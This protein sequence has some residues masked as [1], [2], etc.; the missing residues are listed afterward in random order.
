VDQ[1]DHSRRVALYYDANTPGFLKRGQGGG[2][3][4]IHRAVR[5]PGVRTVADAITW[6]DRHIAELAGEPLSVLDLGCG[7]GGS[8]LRLARRWPRARFRGL[9]LSES[10]AAVGARFLQAAGIRDRASI[11]VEDMAS[12]FLDGPDR[13]AFDLAYAV[14]SLVHLPDPEALFRTAGRALAHRGL[15]AVCDDFLARAPRDSAEAGMLD[16]FRT[17]WRT[18]PLVSPEEARLMASRCGLVQVSDEDLTPW[19][20]LRRPRDRAITALLAL[21]GGRANPDRPFWGNLVGGDAL[22]RLLVAGVLAYRFILYRSGS[23]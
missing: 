21:A 20:V 16:R 14:E 1:H 18:G 19:L 22:Q 13:G 23:G 6:V 9:T 12:A 3:L 11:V 17:G 8:I 10:Q 2:A 4:A 7:V 15:L 5:A